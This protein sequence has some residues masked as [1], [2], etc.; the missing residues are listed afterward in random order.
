MIRLMQSSD[1]GAAMRLKE[2]AGWNQTS[3]DWANCLAVEPEGCWVC[4]QD[5]RVTATTTAICYG[6]DLAW[7]GMVLVDPEFRN[8]GL[9]RRLMEHCLEWLAARQIR[10]IKLDASDMG[11]PLYEKL[12]FH[13]ERTT[14]RWAASG[15]SGPKLLNSHLPVD[16]IS[17]LDRECFGVDRSRLFQRLLDAFPTQGMWREDEGFALGRPGSNAY[18]LGPCSAQNPDS[19]RRLIQSLMEHIGGSQFFWDLFPDN[20]AVVNLARE[21]GFERKR[22]LIRMF[23]HP[24]STIPGRPECVFAGAGFEYG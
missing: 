2:A 1:I 13:T 7:I 17:S 23:L 15:N 19:A 12:G 18:F 14:E 22:T 4:E 20:D 16:P 3:Q 11:F 21:L 9:A 24:Q 8:R 6:S 10:Q 5:G